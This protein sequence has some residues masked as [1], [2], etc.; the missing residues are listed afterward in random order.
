MR[1]DIEK[2]RKV[3]AI[4][5]EKGQTKGLICKEMGMS[6][7]TLQNLLTAELNSFNRDGQSGLRA[8]TL[9]IIQDF[10]KRHI[11]DLNYAG[12]KAETIELSTEPLIHLKPG[13]K[14]KPM[15]ELEEQGKGDFSVKLK[16]DAGEDDIVRIN[17]LSPDDFRA[18]FCRV[19]LEAL[20]R[21]VLVQIL[22]ESGYSGEL[23]KKI[24]I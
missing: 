12:I 20:S 11:D 2:F 1:E 15:K 10:N 18:A 24:V 7:P 6:G 8:S 13:V 22:Q 17:E 19:W 9:G 16:K 4:I 14:E 5:L 3:V 21:G 23:T